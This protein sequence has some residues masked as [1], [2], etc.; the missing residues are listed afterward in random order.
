VELD[1]VLAANPHFAR[2]S[3]PDR[4]ALARALRIDE[5]PDGHVFVR[6]GE[7]GGAI[8]L[9]LDG[10][11]LVCRERG[12]RRHELNRMRPGELFGLVALV[13]KEPRSASCI[14]AG[15]CRVASI[16]DAAAQLLFHQSAPIACAFQKAL[17]AQ[18]ARDFRHVHNRLHWF[19]HHA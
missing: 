9:V 11:V 14:A 1:A 12:E 15:P 4:E 16:P 13:A 7:R 18:L 2:L 3:A 8:Y 19:A 5:H 10:E 6:E 17:A